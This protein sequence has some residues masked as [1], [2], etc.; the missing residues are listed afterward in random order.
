MNPSLKCLPNTGLLFG[1]YLTHSGQQ[2]KKQATRQN[3]Y[4]QLKHFTKGEIKRE[5]EDCIEG[6]L[7]T[8]RSAKK[9]RPVCLRLT[10]QQISRTQRVNQPL[11]DFPTRADS[12]T[13]D[14]KGG[15]H[16]QP[17]L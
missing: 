15:R 2:P 3:L 9:K 17:W 5:K 10:E 11:M 16:E 12:M 1:P 13:A 7:E 8:H 4:S 14:E 6:F